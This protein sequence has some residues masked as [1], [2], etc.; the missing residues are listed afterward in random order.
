METPPTQCPCGLSFDIA[1]RLCQNCRGICEALD[2]N[3]IPCGERLADHPP[4]SQGKVIEF[5]DL[6]HCFY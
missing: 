3:R 4:Q 5:F 2:A 6:I 1:S